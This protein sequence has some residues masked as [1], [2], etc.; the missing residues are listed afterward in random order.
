MQSSDASQFKRL[1]LRAIKET[2]T[3]FSA[4][5]SEEEEKPISYFEAILGES[6][7]FGCFSDDELIAKF[8]ATRDRP[9]KLNHKAYLWGLYVDPSCR[10]E[11]IAQDLF[12]KVMEQCKIQG[13]IHFRAIVT[14]GNVRANTFFIRNGFDQIGTEH[15]S[16]YFDSQFYDA[17][18]FERIE[19]KI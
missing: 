12:L 2:P 3:A 18:I 14:A 8:C 6:V 17:D 4:E 19:K 13:I 5:E 10:R 7:V 1:R 16:L 11:G 15:L 9:K